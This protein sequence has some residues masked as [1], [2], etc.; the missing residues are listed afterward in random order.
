MCAGAIFWAHIRQVGFGC[1]GLL[2]DEIAGCVSFFVFSLPARLLACHVHVLCCSPL[3]V[4]R[5]TGPIFEIPCKEIFARSIPGER[6]LSRGP[7]LEAK[8]RAIHDQYW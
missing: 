7:I 4:A 6:V 2:L 8:C 5:V 3:S 1:S